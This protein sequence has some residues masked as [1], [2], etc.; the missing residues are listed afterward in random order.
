MLGGF[1]KMIADIVNYHWHI[2]PS[3]I[4]LLLGGLQILVLGLIADMIAKR[5][6]P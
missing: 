1:G 5:G 6:S 3:T 4:I 2:A